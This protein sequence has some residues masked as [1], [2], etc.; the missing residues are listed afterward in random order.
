MIAIATPSS[1]IVHHPSS[2]IIGA[3]VRTHIVRSISKSVFKQLPATP[4]RNNLLGSFN[5]ME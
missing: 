2:I 3:P 4:N 1:S 5:Q